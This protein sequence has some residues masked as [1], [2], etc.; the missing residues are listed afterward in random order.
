MGLQEGLRILAHHPG[1][2][3]VEVVADDKEIL[4]LQSLHA[5]CKIHDL[6]PQRVRNVLELS[7]PGQGHDHP[8]LLLHHSVQAAH[9][10]FQVR[11][12]GQR[13]LRQVLQHDHHRRESADHQNR[14]QHADVGQRWCNLELVMDVSLADAEDPRLRVYSELLR[15]ISCRINDPSRPVGGEVLVNHSAQ[16]VGEAHGHRDHPEHGLLR[17]QG[18]EDV[19]DRP[20]GGLTVARGH[21]C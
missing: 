20:R 3:L 9:N 21:E 11:P 1:S 10:F 15:V 2:H 7:G 6:P 19:A 17:F 12:E 8:G 16:R 14:T 18:A 4:L 13:V 5:V